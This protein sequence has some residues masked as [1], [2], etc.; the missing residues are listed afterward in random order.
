LADE[1]AFAY[2]VLARVVRP[3]GRH[4]EVLADLL[5]DFPE[6][7][8]ERRQVFL[9]PP[10]VAEAQTASDTATEAEL[11]DFWMPQG[12]NAGRVVLKFAGCDSIS[13]AEALGGLL[14]AIPQE[15]RA[16]LDQDEFYIADLVGC[17]IVTA[18][19]TVGQV[20]A[21]DTVSSGTPLLVVRTQDGA[22]L[23]LPFVQ[24]FLKSADIAGKRIEMQLPEGLL[25][26][27]Q[28]PEK[29]PTESVKNK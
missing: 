19:G 25:E 24:K 27:N 28:A 5:T 26:I 21:V 20:E 17:E 23:L 9:L 8:A 15:Q 10:E 6:K 12:K 4:G 29:S 13:E 1:T 16:Q 3:Q 22:E 11:E 14:V 18:T 7:F 2:T